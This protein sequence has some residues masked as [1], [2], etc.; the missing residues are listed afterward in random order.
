MQWKLVSAF[1]TGAVLASGIVYY[2]VKP[3]EVARQEA[4]KATVPVAPAVAPVS[5][6][7][8]EPAAPVTEA[9]PAHLPPPVR[10]KRS[11][12]PPPVRLPK[13]VRQVVIARNDPP[14]TPAPA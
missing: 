1:A 3:Q 10:E 4:P 13:E 11:P 12:M 7:I 6:P 2:A 8:A 9:P 5:A 14:P